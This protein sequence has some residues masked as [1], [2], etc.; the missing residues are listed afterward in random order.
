[1]NCDEVRDLIAAY[2][3]G[4]ATPEERKAVEDHLQTCDLHDELAGIQAGTTNVAAREAAADRFD[5][6][7][8]LSR[9]GAST[10]PQAQCEHCAGHYP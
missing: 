9:P 7:S 2:T 1:M 4:T 5:G 6:R 10:T 3:L 8:N